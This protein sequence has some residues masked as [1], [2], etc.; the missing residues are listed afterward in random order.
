MTSIIMCGMEFLID[1]QTPTVEEMSHS[2]NA[3]ALRFFLSQLRFKIAAATSKRSCDFKNPAAIL[4]LL[5]RFNN[6]GKYVCY[7]TSGNIH[8]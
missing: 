6:V 1:S 3:A 8:I 4:R 5:L 2:K 7:I